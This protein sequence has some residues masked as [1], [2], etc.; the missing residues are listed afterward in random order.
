MWG[1]SKRKN[2]IGTR[3]RKKEAKIKA[4]EKK[5][6]MRKRDAAATKK[7]ADLRRKL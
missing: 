2:T 5:L 1:S 6:D 4:I 3:V 7:L